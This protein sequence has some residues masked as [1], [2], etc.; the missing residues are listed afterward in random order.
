MADVNEPRE[1]NTDWLSV[2]GW[3]VVMILSPLVGMM[4][5]L[6]LDG[7]VAGPSVAFIIGLSI[8]AVGTSAGATQ[9]VPAI[10]TRHGRLDKPRSSGRLGRAG[11]QQ[12]TGRRH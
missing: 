1:Q 8:A 9:P 2:P 7:R 10:L 11:R 3:L 4:G 12:Q 6:W 5:A